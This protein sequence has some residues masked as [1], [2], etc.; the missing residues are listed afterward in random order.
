MQFPTSSFIPVPHAGNGPGTPRCGTGRRSWCSATCLAFE[1]GHPVDKF[2]G[3][4]PS[5]FV[6]SPEGMS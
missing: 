4:F 1:H 5:L 2:R 6:K 3:R